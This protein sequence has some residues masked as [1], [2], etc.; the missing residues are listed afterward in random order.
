[1]FFMETRDGFCSV[2]EEGWGEDLCVFPW[3]TWGFA[4]PRIVLG[5]KR[6]PF[7]CRG[8]AGRGQEAILRGDFD[9]K[10]AF[11]PY[12]FPY[13][14][15]ANPQG[16]GKD[17][18]IFRPCCRIFL[19]SFFLACRVSYTSLSCAI[20]LLF[21]S[22]CFSYPPFSYAPFSYASPSHL[23]ELSSSVI[24]GAQVLDPD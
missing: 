20:L 5:L 21:S 19:F 12:P 23:A 14:R 17:G 16:D 3:E 22:P 18:R 2:W 1:M 8:P 10:S 7:R 6:T 13:I 4:V 24:L 9:T 15:T 11:W